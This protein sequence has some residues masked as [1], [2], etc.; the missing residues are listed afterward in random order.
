LI[1][2]SDSLSSPVAGVVVSFEFPKIIPSPCE[3]Y[4]K[5]CCV[6]CVI[7]IVVVDAVVVVVVV[8]VAKNSCLRLLE[9][10][11]YTGISRVFYSKM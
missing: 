6:V 9:C 7:E 10:T 8:V 3:K 5:F 1:S 4:V 2:P 11:R